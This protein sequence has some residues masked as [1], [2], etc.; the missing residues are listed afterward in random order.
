MISS[1]TES[2]FFVPNFHVAND[3][4][5]CGQARE[6]E[7][8]R[9][10]ERVEGVYDCFKAEEGYGVEKDEGAEH[11]KHLFVGSGQAG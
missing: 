10:R 8:A 2:G 1:P 9:T 3:E 11:Q 7:S 5:D 4:I 6:N